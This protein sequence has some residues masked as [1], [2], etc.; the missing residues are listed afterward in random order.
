MTDGGSIPPTDGTDS[1]PHSI[2]GISIG[3]GISTGITPVVW[4]GLSLIKGREE[5]LTDMSYQEWNNL[6]SKHLA[7]CQQLPHKLH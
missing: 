5:D 6:Q 2:V 4:S 1:G 3:M 7:L